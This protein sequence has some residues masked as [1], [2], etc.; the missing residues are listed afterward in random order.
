VTDARALYKAALLRYAKDETHAGA[1]AGAD[2]RATR[3]NPLCGDRV[4]L[5]VRMAPQRDARIAAV[6][7]EVKGCAICKAS[8]AILA[9]AVP[10]R[11]A[12][13]ARALYAALEAM[14][15][16][17]DLD[18]RAGGPESDPL[19]PLRGVRL[20][21]GRRRCATLPWEALDAA[22]TADAGAPVTDP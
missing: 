16:A 8:A 21:R 3:N 6:A 7:H 18:A 5:H 14:L 19:A 22:L 4:T 17:T 2:A 13:E 9:E 20:F 10:G 12:A 1:L 11:T 15:G